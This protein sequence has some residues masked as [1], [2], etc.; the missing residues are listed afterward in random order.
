MR[1]SIQES[2]ARGPKKPETAERGNSTLFYFG[3]TGVVLYA[4]RQTVDREGQR[5]IMVSEFVHHRSYRGPVKGVILD[6]A[7]TTMDYGCYAA[8]GCPARES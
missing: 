3:N 5:S 1:G 7:G 2:A 6:S 8:V 4:I